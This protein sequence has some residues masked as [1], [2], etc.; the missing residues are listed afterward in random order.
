MLRLSSRG[1]RTT[2]LDYFHVSD[3]GEG[4]GVVMYKA[5]AVVSVEP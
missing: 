3:E 2:L 5:Y 1:G 4:G